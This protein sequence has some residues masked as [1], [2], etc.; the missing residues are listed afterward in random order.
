MFSEKELQ[1]QD[2]MRDR[3]DSDVDDLIVCFHRFYCFIGQEQSNC[4]LPKT[5][6]T[7]ILKHEVMWNV[8]ILC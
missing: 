8:D 1:E 2:K 5:I 3:D 6:K 4:Q 7:K